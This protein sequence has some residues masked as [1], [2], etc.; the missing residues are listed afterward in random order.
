MNVSIPGLIII[1]RLQEGGKSHLIRYIMH[2]NRKKFDW[3]I[4]FSNT[5]FSADNFNYIDKHF[6]YRKYDEL[7][8]LKL[9]HEQL[10]KKS[11]K[12]CGFVIFDDCLFGKQW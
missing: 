5:G 12:H 3:G 6:L 9:I 10:V 11:K 8:N 4:I 1:C 7:A 2:K